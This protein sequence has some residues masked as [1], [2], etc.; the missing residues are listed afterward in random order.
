MPWGILTRYLLK[1]SVSAFVFT[2]PIRK[3]DRLET[4]PKW[5]GV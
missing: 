3:N 2:L 4:F 5:G 1:K